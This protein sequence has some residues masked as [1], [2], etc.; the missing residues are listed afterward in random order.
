[1]EQIERIAYYEALLR[2]AE[3]ALQEYE[4]AKERVLALSAEIGELDAYLGSDAWKQDFLDDEEGRLPADLPRGV[5]SEDGIYNVVTAFREIADE[6]AETAADEI[7][8]TIA[9][10]R[11]EMSA[12]EVT[13]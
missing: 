12:E 4:K 9:E 6:T 10:G 8:E 3:T 13:D 7:M 5:L 11:P 2:K 1:M